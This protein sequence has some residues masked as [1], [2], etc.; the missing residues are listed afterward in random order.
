M[1]LIDR[2]LRPIQVVTFLVAAGTLIAHASLA[3]QVVAVS[4][5]GVAVGAQALLDAFAIYKGEKVGTT[6]GG[7][8][9]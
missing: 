4:V 6:L 7:R 3:V 2:I 8:P 1:N 5:F 9:R